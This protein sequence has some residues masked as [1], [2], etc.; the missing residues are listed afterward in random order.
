MPS[1]ASIGVSAGARL[2]LS[3]KKSASS[4]TSAH[5]YDFQALE[6][7]KGEDVAQRLVHQH[8]QPLQH[9]ATASSS[10][11]RQPPPPRS[12]VVTAQHHQAANRQLGDLE[13]GD[14]LYGYKVANV[15]G[16]G[17]F[18]V[19]YFVKNLE[20]S[21]SH[22]ALKRIRNGRQSEV[23]ILDH[24]EAHPNVLQM[25]SSYFSAQ[26]FLD[27]LL[28]HCA[29]G[30]LKRWIRRCVN[31]D[32]FFAEPQI[33]QYAVQLASALN[34]VHAAGVLH[35]DL[36]PANVLLDAQ[37]VCKLAD[38]GL[39]RKI[40]V[41]PA[42]ANLR[43]TDSTRN[44]TDELLFDEEDGC[45]QMQLFSKV[46]TP[47]YMAPEVLA[48]KGYNSG[49][50]VWSLGCVLYELLTLKQPFRT[51]TTTTSVVGEDVG[52]QLVTG[53]GPPALQSYK[54]SGGNGNASLYELFQRIQRGEYQKLKHHA[55][56]VRVDF[57]PAFAA[58][59]TDMLQVQPTRR[60]SAVQARH[61]VTD[62]ILGQEE[63]ADALREFASLRKAY[64]LKPVLL[65]KAALAGIAKVEHDPVPVTRFHANV[66]DPSTACRSANTCSSTAETKTAPLERNSDRDN[67]QSRPAGFRDTA[68]SSATTTRGDVDMRVEQ[69]QQ[70]KE[71]SA[72]GKTAEELL[73]TTAA[74]KQGGVDH[75]HHM[76]K[77]TGFGTTTG[78][79]REHRPQPMAIEDTSDTRSRTGSFCSSASSNR[80]NLVVLEKL[81]T[82]P[83]SSTVTRSRIVDKKRSSHG[84]CSVISGPGEPAGGGT[85]SSSSSSCATRRRKSREKHQSRPRSCSGASSELSKSGSFI[86][87]QFC[88]RRPSV[89]ATTRRGGPLRDNLDFLHTHNAES[90]RQNAWAAVTPDDDVMI[91]G[92]ASPQHFSQQDD[93]VEREQDEP[94][95]ASEQQQLLFHH[96]PAAPSVPVPVGPRSNSQ[97][98]ES[99]GPHG[100]RD[101]LRPPISSCDA[102]A[103]SV[104]LAD[105]DRNL[106]SLF[107]D[108]HL[109][110]TREDQEQDGQ[111]KQ[112][113]PLSSS[114]S[115]NRD[116]TA[117]TEHAQ[118]NTFPSEGDDDE[119]SNG[120]HN[121][122][123]DGEPRKGKTVEASSSSSTSTQ[124]RL[125]PFPCETPEDAVPVATHGSSSRMNLCSLLQQAATTD[126]KTSL[127]TRNVEPTSGVSRDPLLPAPLCVA[128]EL[129]EKLKLLGYIGSC[130]GSRSSPVDS[131]F[132]S[133][134]ST[135]KA[136]R[137][138]QPH[139]LHYLFLMDDTGSPSTVPVSSSDG[140]HGLAMNDLDDD[141]E[142]S[143]C[144]ASV[145]NVKESLALSS[146]LLD[147]EDEE[148]TI[149]LGESC[150]M[151]TSEH[152][153]MRKSTAASSA[154]GLPRATARTNRSGVLS[155]QRGSSFQF[156]LGRYSQFFATADLLLWLLRQL[157]SSHS[158]ARSSSAVVESLAHELQELRSRTSSSRSSTAS[159]P[160]TSLDQA[161][162]D[163]L[164]R[165]VTKV[166]HLSAPAVREGEEQVE[167]LRGRDTFAGQEGSP[168]SALEHEIQNMLRISIEKVCPS[169]DLLRTELAHGYGESVCRVLNELATL[170]LVVRDFHFRSPLLEHVHNSG[171]PQHN[172][173]S[174]GPVNASAS[175]VHQEIGATPQHDEREISFL[176]SIRGSKT[177]VWN[178]F[179]R[180]DLSLSHM[181]QSGVFA[182]MLQNFGV[183]DDDVDPVGASKQC[184]ATSLGRDGITQEV[185]GSNSTSGAAADAGAASRQRSKVP[186]GNLDLD[187][188][189]NNADQK[190]REA[191]QPMGDF[192]SSA[193]DSARPAPFE[194]EPPGDEPSFAASTRIKRSNP[195][196]Q[197]VDALRT[198]AHFASMKDLHPLDARS[199][200]SSSSTTNAHGR[201]LHCADPTR[202]QDPSTARR[203]KTTA[204]GA[205]DD[206]KMDESKN[207]SAVF[208]HPGV[209]SGV[210]DGV[211]PLVFCEADHLQLIK[212]SKRNFPRDAPASDD[213]D[214]KNEVGLVVGTP[215]PSDDES[216]C[217]IDPP[218]NQ[219]TQSLECQ[220]H[221]DRYLQRR[222]QGGQS[223]A[224]QGSFLPRSADDEPGMQT[225]TAPDPP[226]KNRP[227]L[228][229]LRKIAERE[230]AGS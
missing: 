118:P 77:D 5:A 167:T 120:S 86:R 94:S 60:P 2:A 81:P 82:S 9:P 49:C 107:R 170:V 76:E 1:T 92:A 225:V 110:P 140:G 52:A 145:F 47:L 131:V 28:E 115:S 97:L 89:S 121:V 65:S 23:D 123:A 200:G 8:H 31:K 18:S 162:A 221:F 36:K 138:R 151:L 153:A 29:L 80:G 146:N 48:N 90:R 207:T 10:A 40:E 219:R 183:A 159:W 169:P 127:M 39:A 137:A 158:T 4:T 126:L 187:P 147:G 168:E 186:A 201:Q 144:A 11:P 87:D 95:L 51:L 66:Q 56:T 226:P 33:W 68:S 176:S 205:V 220:A 179:A 215:K 59:V 214:K 143:S 229:F 132:A 112:L 117:S 133:R 99:C 230:A 19:V 106:D 224:I 32:Y 130:D 178:S 57:H 100:V 208:Y 88:L 38:F 74:K 204:A 210:G 135:A 164:R 104:C 223:Q 163:F 7:G 190:F 102:T 155:H 195:R 206:V 22:A 171:R 119:T 3:P 16:R 61:C 41:R 222:I 108:L 69:V 142:L 96:V 196:S 185:P 98:Q 193:H 128:E 20:D 211:V 156:V 34:A 203:Q 103:S 111:P 125:P 24:M 25:Y 122:T 199:A 129:G 85:S 93:T 14:R 148:G 197:Q 228:D 181:V 45:D 91:E 71:A 109:G 83:R 101:H 191:A 79:L 166:L 136:S 213:E 152:S 105:A 202:S 149:E 63:Q 188:S 13:K 175:G 180:F 189:L 46:G 172:L 173:G 134:Q 182:S 64:D 78:S 139:F 21:S 58:L 165:L 154:H 150:M 42:T 6:F 124:R 35:R 53:G 75:D 192:Y 54:K 227:G 177:N 12:R 218:S 209:I 26:G 37:G 73:D 50:D 84:S 212:R 217:T 174:A 67:E 62:G 141:L 198:T 160:S 184:T 15:L 55:A 27:L 194:D 216:N 116:G 70:V 17:K 43:A 114:S 157:L 161:V 30:D 72:F 113:H 44:T